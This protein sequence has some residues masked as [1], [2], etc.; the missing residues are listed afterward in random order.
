GVQGK[1]THVINSNP[2]D[3]TTDVEN[4]FNAEQNQIDESE[5]V[6]EMKDGAIVSINIKTEIRYCPTGGEY[7]ER[8]IVLTNEIVLKIN[9]QLTTA[10]EYVAPK[11]VS[12][13][14]G[15]LGLNNAKFYI[16]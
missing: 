15:S 6:V 7:T 12:T 16:L 11:D 14:L 2:T 5:M 3:E 9:D 1:I 13:S 8:N 4:Y 10:Q